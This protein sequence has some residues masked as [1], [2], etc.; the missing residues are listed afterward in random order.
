VYKNVALIRRRT[1]DC[2]IFIGPVFIH[3]HSDFNTYAQFF[4]HLSAKLCGCNFQQLTLGSD[5]ELAIRKCFEHYFARSSS[6]TCSLHIKDNVGRQLDELLGKGSALRK[7]L[8]GALFGR[9]GLIECDDVVSFDAAVDTLR[10]GILTEAPAAFVDYFERHVL[11][12]MRQNVACGPSFNKWT[13]NNS[14]AANHV[15]KE[16]VQWKRNQI[17]DLIDK[18]RQLVDG[19][20]ADADRALC[21]LGDFALRAA[22][23]RHRVSVDVWKGM[24]ANQRRKA[25][26]A[27][28]RIHSMQV[29][30]TDGRITVPTT[31]GGGKKPHQTKRGRNERA[32]PKAAKKLKVDTD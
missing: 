24:S 17:P 10:S 1:H 31:P 5:G 14:E 11:E 12:S 22:N 20:Y 7:N 4:G 23:A 2:P 32:R 9:E 28:F 26:D 13:N 30:S 15:L 18:I 19:Q 29:T 8:F 27:A 3:G 6:V 21:G 25:A 16:S